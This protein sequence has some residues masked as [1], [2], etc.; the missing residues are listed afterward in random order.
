MTAAEVGSLLG[1]KGA[2]VRVSLDAAD[3]I[4]LT[5]PL[6]DCGE[7]IASGQGLIDL[8]YCEL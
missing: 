7:D 5:E 4:E 2:V 8:T 1:E 6:S 3:D